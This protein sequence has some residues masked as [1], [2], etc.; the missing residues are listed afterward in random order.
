MTDGHTILFIT[1]TYC[2]VIYSKKASRHYYLNMYE[3]AP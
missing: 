3:N 2:D 1:A